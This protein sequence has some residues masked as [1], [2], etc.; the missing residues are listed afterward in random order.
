MED[1]SARKQEER[2]VK[3]RIAR[4][5]ARYA[6]LTSRTRISKYCED[7]LGMVQ[8]DAGTVTRLSV[9]GD[10]GALSATLEF[11]EEPVRIPDVMGSDV[12]GLTEV[13]RK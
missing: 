9:E 1:I 5:T 4:L 3:E 13:I 12:G 6:S 11:V 7:R 2:A 10:E 8:A